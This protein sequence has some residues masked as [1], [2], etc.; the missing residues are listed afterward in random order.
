MI[1]ALIA[2][3]RNPRVLADLSIGEMRAKRAQL[4][5]ALDGKFQE[6]HGGLARIILDQI[7]ALTAHIGQ[8]SD[9]VGELIAAIP[10]AQ[11]VDA[12][13]TA[14]PLAGTGPRRPDAA[15][16]RAAG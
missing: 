15:G 9:R 6:H 7:D 2:G 5:E 11:G 10:A 4:A 16:R 8:L 1:E 12:D 13:G 3:E 14:G